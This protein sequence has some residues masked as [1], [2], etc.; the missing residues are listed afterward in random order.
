MTAVTNRD[1][2]KAAVDNDEWQRFRLSLK[3]LPTH[4]KLTELYAYYSRTAHTH[5][6]IDLPGG[7]ATHG[8]DTCV[9]CIRVDNYLKALCRGGQI[10]RGSHL[11]TLLDGTIIILK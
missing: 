4:E 7:S 2:I 10:K 6:S 8:R 5:A 11:L 3:G 9:G 1:R